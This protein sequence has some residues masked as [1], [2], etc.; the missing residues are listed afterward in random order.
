[1]SALTP[2]ADIDQK[3]SHVRFGPKADLATWERDGCFTPK[4]ARPRIPWWT[5]LSAASEADVHWVAPQLS[6]VLHCFLDF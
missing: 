1:M 4:F 2:R 3:L 6:D 5:E